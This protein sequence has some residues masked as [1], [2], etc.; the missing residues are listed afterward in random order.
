MPGKINVLLLED[1]KDVGRAGEIV[2][3]SEG[4]ARNSLFP[5]GKAA[6][7]TPSVQKDFAHKKAKAEKVKLQKFE[8]LQK[9][10]EILDNTEIIITA[11]VKDGVDIYGSITKKQVMEELQVKAGV[12]IK[13][14]D[15]DMARAIKQVGSYDVTIHL[16]PEIE[17]VIKLTV[18]ADASSLKSD[19]DDE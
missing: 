3:V 12:R 19:S 11:K 1:I 18:I 16:S 10:A 2:T 7:A 9:Q 15:V 8:E 14:G 4:Y 6:Q 5:E 17:C 13:E